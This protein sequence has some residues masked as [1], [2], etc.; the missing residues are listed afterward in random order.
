VRERCNAGHLLEYRTYAGRDHLS[1]VA[2]D[3]PLIRD[4]VQWTQDRIDKKPSSAACE[5][6]NTQRSNP[7]EAKNRAAD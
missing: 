6:D 2:P 5:E 1:I 3:S 4:L 7:D